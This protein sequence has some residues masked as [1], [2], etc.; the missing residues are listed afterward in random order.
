MEADEVTYNLHV[1]LRYEIEK[2]L[3]NGDLEVDD[4]PYGVEHHVQSVV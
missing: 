4:L 1:M 2:Q 3:F